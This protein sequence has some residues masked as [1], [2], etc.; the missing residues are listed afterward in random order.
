MRDLIYSFPYVLILIC[1]SLI[2]KA[3]NSDPFNS[4]KADRT[5]SVS[6]FSWLSGFWAGNGMGGYN[7][8]FWSAP[9]NN[10]MVGLY[11]HIKN[12]EIVFYELLTI[13]EHKGNI[14]LRLRHFNTDLTGWEEKDQYQEFDL[15]NSGNNEIEFDGLLY[16]RTGQ[17]SLFITAKFQQQNGAIHTEEFRFRRYGWLNK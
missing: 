14:V 7:E 8:E 10:T 11:R 4:I 17:D 2:C 15:L 5:V 3:Q 12:G 16:R 13:I 1:I 6:D 9:A